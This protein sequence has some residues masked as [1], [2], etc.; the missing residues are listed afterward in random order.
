M[1]RDSQTHT[2]RFEAAMTVI[3]DLPCRQTLLAGGA[4]TVSPAFVRRRI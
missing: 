2:N 1:S 4:R 3:S